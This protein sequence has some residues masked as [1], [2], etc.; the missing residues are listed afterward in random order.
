MN[1]QDVPLYFIF[2]II[3]IAVIIIEYLILKQRFTKTKA[4]SFEPDEELSDTQ[5]D[6]IENISELDEK[7]A[8]DIMVHRGD[9]V[10]FDG[11]EKLSVALEQFKDSNYSRFPVYIDDLDNI[12]GIV[13]MRELLLYSLDKVNQA[14]KMKDIDG[15]MSAPVF[16]PETHGIN[17][18]FSLMQKEKTHLVLVRDEYGQTSGLVSMENIIEEIVGD[19]LDEHDKEEESLIDRGNGLYIMFGRTE[20]EEI[21][22][23]LGITYENEEIETLNGLLINELGRI[24]KDGEN[25]NVEYG[26][27]NFE[28]MDVKN[29]MIQGVKVT[30]A[31]FDEVEYETDKC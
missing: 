27:F 19:I 26:G 13:H 18:L 31:S 17:D 29:N 20:L 8:K 14:K 15:L 4:E 28:I 12:I 25:L 1:D 11:N 10:G 5:Q 3:L 21:Q 22:E 30:K 7:D 6:M 2:A 24:P 16:V 23:V 9:I